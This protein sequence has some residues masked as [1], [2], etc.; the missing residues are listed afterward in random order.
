[1]NTAAQIFVALAGAFHLV[2]FAMESLLFRKPEVWKRFRI[3]SAADAEIVRNW[4]FNQ[5]FYNL[6]L[7]LGA[8]GGLFLFGDKGE[9]IALFACACMVGAGVVLIATDRRML[10]SAAMQAGP[11]LLG[12]ILAAAL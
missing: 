11:P 8:I 3:A 5:G 4:A 12:L 10:Q 6:F 1:M 2:I 7:G 9:A